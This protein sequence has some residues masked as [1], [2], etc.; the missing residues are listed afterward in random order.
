MTCRK[1]VQT[2]SQAEQVTRGWRGR[3]AEASGR[4]RRAWRS[5]QWL[6]AREPG[7]VP[8]SLLLNEPPRLR[9]L[10]FICKFQESTKSVKYTR[11]GD[12]ARPAL[13]GRFASTE[14]RGT[15]V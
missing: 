1:E 12:T 8:T 3:R 7:L 6:G 11:A 14:R 9:N 4:L 5:A 10:I 13:T 2:W 15:G